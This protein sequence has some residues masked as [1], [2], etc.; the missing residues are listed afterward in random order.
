MKIYL[1]IFITIMLL[2][3]ICYSKITLSISNPINPCTLTKRKIESLVEYSIS[4][5]H[6]DGKI[7]KSSFEISHDCDIFYLRNNFLFFSSNFYS[8]PA[9]YMLDCKNKKLYYFDPKF[10]LDSGKLNNQV[11][12][13][14]DDESNI[15]NLEKWESHDY[16]N[17]ARLLC[18]SP[19]FNRVHLHPSFLIDADKKTISFLTY[20][21]NIIPKT[22]DVKSE[23]IMKDV[24]F[25]IK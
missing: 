9:I 12:S 1:C 20:M 17:Y 10:I 4:L 18:F 11:I 16:G 23:F 8:D 2:T 6:S 24:S 3:E 25:Y 22:Y 7:N 13:T 5:Y 21:D 14:S 19:I 15:W